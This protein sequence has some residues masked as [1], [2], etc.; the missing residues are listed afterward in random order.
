M[1]Y[2][3][4]THFVQSCI[5]TVYTKRL[6]LDNVVLSFYTAGFQQIVHGRHQF[7]YIEIIKLNNVN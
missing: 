6:S 7:I 3:N 5:Q 1:H 2:F 4:K